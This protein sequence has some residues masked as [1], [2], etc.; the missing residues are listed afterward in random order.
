MNEFGITWI[1]NPVEDI[2]GIGLPSLHCGEFCMEK[3]K[4]SCTI[5]CLGDADACPQYD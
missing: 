2:L 1:K 3:T 4:D 5:F